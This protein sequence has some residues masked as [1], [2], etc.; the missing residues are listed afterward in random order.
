VAGAVVH[1]TF[2]PGHTAQCTMASRGTCSM[3]SP[4]EPTS[5]AAI[6]FTVTD[7]DAAGFTY[8]ADQNAATQV[9]I[10]RR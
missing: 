4:N 7:V 6:V 1:G 5:T 3:S 8:A 10:N 9:T 2:S